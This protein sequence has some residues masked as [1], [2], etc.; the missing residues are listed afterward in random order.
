MLSFNLC[1]ADLSTTK[2]NM[3][4]N[5]QSA[6]IFTIRKVFYV[7]CENF[8]VRIVLGGF[9]LSNM[10][11]KNGYLDEFFLWHRRILFQLKKKI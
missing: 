7:C 2:R 10:I 1:N 4:K 9:V 11:K 3:F 6:R 5:R 8:S